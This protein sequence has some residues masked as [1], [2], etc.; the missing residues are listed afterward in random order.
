MAE[1]VAAWLR[2]DIGPAVLKLGAPLR[3][4]DNF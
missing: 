3:G 4:L 1:E 2:E